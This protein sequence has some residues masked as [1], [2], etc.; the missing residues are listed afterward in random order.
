MSLDYATLTPDDAYL[1]QLGPGV[2]LMDNHKWALVAWERQ[3]FAHATPCAAARRLS[4]GR[5]R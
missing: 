5:R 1:V 3:R 2:W 4:L